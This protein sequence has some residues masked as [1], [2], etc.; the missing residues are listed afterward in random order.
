MRDRMRPRAETFNGGEPGVI[1]PLDGSA[2]WDE[3]KELM[4]PTQYN[5]GSE[6][7]IAL[8]EKRLAAGLPLWIEGD[9]TDHTPTQRPNWILEHR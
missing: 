6:A 2:P 7:K 8:L 5:P 3:F 4:S 1:E 9:K